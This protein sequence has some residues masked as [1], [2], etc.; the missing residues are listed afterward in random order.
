M[1]NFGVLEAEIDLVVW[2]TLANFNGFRV[3]PARQSNS[4]RQPNFAALKRGRHLCLAGQ[5]S[6]WALAHILVCLW[7]VMVCF[8]V[9]I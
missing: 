3:L 6:R 2:G 8:Y 5:P 1:V 7:C 9:D 4:E